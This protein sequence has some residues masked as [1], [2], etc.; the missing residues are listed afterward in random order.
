MYGLVKSGASG[1]S[2]RHDMRDKCSLCCEMIPVSLYRDDLSRTAKVELYSTWNDPQTSPQ[3]VYGCVQRQ[4]RSEETA[5]PKLTSCYNPSLP[6]LCRSYLPGAPWQYTRLAPSPSYSVARI[7]LHE[8]K[9]ILTPS[10]KENLTCQKV[11]RLPQRLVR[12]FRKKMK[13]HVPC[14]PTGVSSKYTPSD[15]CS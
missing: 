5:Y 12:E 6:C 15:S 13:A 10:Q 7:A 4:T 14:W 2:R 3:Q 8:T 9:G 1:Q 11:Y